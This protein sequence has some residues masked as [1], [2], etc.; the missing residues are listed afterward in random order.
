MSLFTQVYSIGAVRSALW[1]LWYPYV[2][3]RLRGEEVLFLNYGFETDPPMGLALSSADDPDRAC[4]QLY[5]HVGTQVELAGKHVV[6]VSCGHGGGASYLA[7]TQLP[8]T[9]T[10]IDLNAAGIRLCTERH[11][12]EGLSFFQGD[13]ETLP[14]ASETVDVV[15]NIEASHCYGEFSQFLEEVARVLR[16]GGFFL[17]AD[18]RFSD[19]RPAWELALASC[20]LEVRRG[21][22]ISLDVVRGLV[23]PERTAV[24]LDLVARQLPK[25][26]HAMGRDIAGIPGSYVYRALQGSKA[27]YHSYCYVKPRAEA[28]KNPITGSAPPT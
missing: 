14:F 1:R 25:W 16:P 21:Q 28:T 27:V 3:R 18:F 2:T 13:A 4:I 22:V 20:P 8:A 11:Q 26:L 9:Y 7:R 5:H 10:G 19:D 23:R 17:Y 6:E 24:E 15:I 12:V